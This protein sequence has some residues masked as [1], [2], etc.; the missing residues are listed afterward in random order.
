M[1][2]L[3][4]FGTGP[5]NP[6]KDLIQFLAFAGTLAGWVVIIYLIRKVNRSSKAPAFKISV[7]VLLITTGVIGSVMIFFATLLGL[8]CSG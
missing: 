2:T 3:A 6:N 5:C 1:T 8:A 7:S 4:F